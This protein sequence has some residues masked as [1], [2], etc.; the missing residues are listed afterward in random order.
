MGT[1]LVSVNLPVPVDDAYSTPAG[2]PLIVPA[3]GLLANDGTDTLGDPLRA[4]SASDPPHGT[5]VLNDDGSFAYTPDAGF[6][7]T[8]T[9]TYFAKTV[10]E[11]VSVIPATVTVTVGPTV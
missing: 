11:R 9:F 8:D 10:S 3:P 5:V 1:V 6:I 2:T 4:A 7:G